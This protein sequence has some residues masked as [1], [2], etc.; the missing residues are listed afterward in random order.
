MQTAVVAHEEAAAFLEVVEQEVGLPWLEHRPHEAARPVA[1]E[2][3]AVEQRETYLEASLFVEVGI[4]GFLIARKEVVIAE[5]EGLLALV[6]IRHVLY[7]PD[8]R[9]RVGFVIGIHEIGAR[10]LLQVVGHEAAGYH[11]VRSPLV[12]YLYGA[13]A[14][15]VLAHNDFYI[16]RS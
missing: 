6:L 1:K 9:H 12:A 10:V 13:L 4:D 7:P 11:A 15:L 3:R 8:D 16:V 14:L 2:L 5:T